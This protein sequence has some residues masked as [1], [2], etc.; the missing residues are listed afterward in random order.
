M[1]KPSPSVPPVLSHFPTEVQ[2]AYLRFVED[3]KEADLRI[4]IHAALRDFMPRKVDR[5]APAV[6]EPGQALIGDLGLDSLA[7]AEMVF[8]F[9]DLFQITIPSQEILNLST[10]ADLEGYVGRKLRETVKAA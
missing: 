9:E 3:G 2:S 4:L 6:F 5:P 10:V 8:F 1:S 7:V